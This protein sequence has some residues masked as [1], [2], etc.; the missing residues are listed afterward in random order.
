MDISSANRHKMNGKPANSTEGLLLI[1]EISR[2]VREIKM[3]PRLDQSFWFL[4]RML[5]L[6][7]PE[8]D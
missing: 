6:E 4:T 5:A 2:G 1:L 3:L 8:R 7:L